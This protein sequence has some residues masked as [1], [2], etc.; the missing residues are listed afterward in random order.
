M[1]PRSPQGLF[2][3]GPRTPPK[4]RLDFLFSVIEGLDNDVPAHVLSVVD[5]QS[6]EFDGFSTMFNAS[7]SYSAQGRRAELGLNAATMIRHYKNTG[8]TR[9]V[10]HS[11]GIGVL[12]KL[13]AR[14]SILVNQAAA[15][16]PTYLYGL[17]PSDEVVTPGDATS[18]IPDYSIADLES[19][20]YTTSA[21]LTHEFSP[22]RKLTA[23]A[24]Y[25]YTDRL[26]EH[27]RWADVSSYLIRGEYAQNVS[28]TTSL[29]TGLRY[30]SGRF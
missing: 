30:R 6:L 9:S 11:A 26:R 2:G 24:D 20:L 19:Y 4:H 28:R 22:R 13:P 16:T 21:S 25:A 17:F 14:T 29:T 10:G 8:D 15:Y 12:F 1:P 7:T 3:G 27:L 23:G 18:T 5:P